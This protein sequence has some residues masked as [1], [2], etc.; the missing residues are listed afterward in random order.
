[1]AS[2]PER[3]QVKTMVAEATHRRFTPGACLRGY[4]TQRTYLATLA[5]RSG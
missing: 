1:M 3:D 4:F 5:K 2:L